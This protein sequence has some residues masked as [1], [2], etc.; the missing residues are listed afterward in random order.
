MKEK[1]KEISR[2]YKNYMALKKVIEGTAYLSDDG[3]LIELAALEEGREKGRLE[4]NV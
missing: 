2:L 3:I 1:N 4:E